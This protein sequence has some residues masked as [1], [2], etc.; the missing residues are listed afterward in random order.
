MWLSKIFGNGSNKSELQLVG[1][2]EGKNHL[3]DF[4]IDGRVVLN[5]IGGK[6]AGCVWTGINCL[7]QVPVAGCF[8]HGKEPSFS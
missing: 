7:G 8:E 6:D 4:N 2:P 1:K 3:G 5:K